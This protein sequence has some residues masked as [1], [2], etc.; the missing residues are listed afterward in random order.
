MTRCTALPRLVL[1]VPAIA[2][3][4]PE[5]VANVLGPP[6]RT[7][8]AQLTANVRNRYQRGS[9]EVVFVEGKASWIKLFNTR[10]LQFSKEI[11]PKLGLPSAKPTYVNSS[12]VMSWSNL[13]NLQEVSVYGGEN[14]TISSILICVRPAQ[15]A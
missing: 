10:S 2:L 12:H 9:V 7:N 4:S 5:E 13:A 11:L 14:G 3:K 1:N 15:A 8:G 6:E